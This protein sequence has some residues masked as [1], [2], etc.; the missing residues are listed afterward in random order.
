[1][2]KI[3]SVILCVALLLSLS[4]CARSVPTTTTA[5]AES[6][7]SSPGAS[8]G[9]ST[10][11]KMVGKDISTKPIKIAFLA[12]QMDANPVYWEQGI[13]KACSPYS[14]IEVT[15]FDAGGS[16]ETQN[17]QITECVNQGYDA[18]IINAANSTAIASAITNAEAAGVNVFAINIGIECVYSGLVAA[19]S[20]DAGKVCAQDA[21]SRIKGGN[22]VAIGAPVAMASTVRGAVGFEDTIKAAA[23][24]KFLEEQPGDWSTE[25]ANTIMRDFLTKYNNDIQAVFCHNDLMAIGAAQAIDAAGL[26]GKVLVYGCD[27]LPEAIE[28]IKEGKMAGSVYQDSVLQG[29]TAAEL[30]LYAIAT[31]LDGTK[32]S[33]TPTVRST[34]TVINAENVAKYEK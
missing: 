28:Y 9:A 27:G 21:I 19:D 24:F 16:A 14:N 20:Y 29:V 30:A 3:L 4:A 10:G 17:Q 11:A 13:K 22:C 33:A 1:M 12:A 2:K 31:G 6:S 23:G 32:L 15:T 25:T 7:S 18:I 34:L 26:T 8:T 5:P